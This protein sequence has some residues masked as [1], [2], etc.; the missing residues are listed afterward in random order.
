MTSRD[1]LFYEINSALTIYVHSL[2]TLSKTNL[3]DCAVNSEIFFS[4]LLNLIYNLNLSKKGISKP[5]QKA[6]DSHDTRNKVCAQFTVRSDK[7]KID[8]TIE[9]ATAINQDH[10]YNKL[11]FVVI[12]F[13]VKKKQIE[14]AQTN[15]ELV[16]IDISDLLAI[17]YSQFTTSK[18]IR[19]IHNFLSEELTIKSQDEKIRINSE[20]VRLT[21][22]GRAKAKTLLKTDKEI[23]QIP[24]ELYVQDPQAKLIEIEAIIVNIEEGTYMDA[25]TNDNEFK[26]GNYFFADIYDLKTDGIELHLQPGIGCNV[27]IAPDGRWQELP[28]SFDVKK[29]DVHYTIENVLKLGYIPYSNL[30][31]IDLEGDYCDNKPVL[32]C[33]FN[34]GSPIEEVRYGPNKS[35]LFQMYRNNGFLDP[36]LECTNLL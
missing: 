13:D 20:K 17:I 18:K 11:L 12:D 27:M 23:G 9:K 25:L 4:E 14:D 26:R 28:I 24:I 30:L 19:P 36:S 7:T 16:Q 34:D 31:D 8:E 3:N 22:L 2:K 29:V 1:K 5:N 33:I 15:F 32:Y 21:K 6:I 10:R 35:D